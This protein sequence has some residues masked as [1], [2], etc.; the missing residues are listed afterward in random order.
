MMISL[1]ESVK[2]M[3]HLWP[4]A[5]FRVVLGF[6]ILDSTRRHWN[7]GFLDQPLI[8]KI[9][10]HLWNRGVD[11]EFVHWV[12]NWLTP[13]WLVINYLVM[14][15]L[16]LISIAYIVGFLVRPAAVLAVVSVL[17][18][19]LIFGE[20]QVPEL[21]RLSVAVHLLL[22]LLGAGRCLGFDYYFYKRSRKIWW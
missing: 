13:H 15:T 4:V 1:I 2:Y 11:P 12:Q 6:W 22:M 14:G 10:E 21:H 5:I 3:G 20:P 7:Q 9:L 16:F 18:H 19:N 17:I 8:E